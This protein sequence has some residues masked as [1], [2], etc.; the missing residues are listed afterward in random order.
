M[1]I[2][3]GMFQDYAKKQEL[4]RQRREESRKNSKYNHYRVFDKLPEERAPEPKSATVTQKEVKKPQEYVKQE[5]VK[6]VAKKIS[7]TQLA[8]ENI[9]A[10]LIKLQGLQ[11]KMF[12]GLLKMAQAKR[13][14]RIDEVSAEMLM[15]IIDSSYGNAKLTVSRLAQ[16]GLIERYK[17]KVARGGYYS[18]GFTDEVYKAA[19]MVDKALGVFSQVDEK[20]QVE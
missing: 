12:Y 8:P 9:Q 14:Y 7:N 5:S 18:F 16:K 10:Q 11:K 13:R 19:F 1:A 4:E 2:K 17:G 6:K 15:N 20:E 3:K